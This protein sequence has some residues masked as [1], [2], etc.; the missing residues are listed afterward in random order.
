MKLTIRHIIFCSVTAVI[1]FSSCHS[2][3]GADVVPPQMENGIYLLEDDSSAATR[4][5]FA[6]DT[7]CGA[8]Y[9]DTLCRI[10]EN[11]FTRVSVYSYADGSLELSPEL[12]DCGTVRRDFVRYQN[13]GKSFAF[14][15]H[16]EVVA[17]GTFP[18]DTSTTYFQMKMKLLTT[19]DRGGQLAQLFNGEKK[20]PDTKRV[21]DS[22]GGWTEKEYYPDGKLFSEIFF[23]PEVSGHDRALLRTGV[24]RKCRTYYENGNLRYEKEQDTLTVDGIHGTWYEKHFYPQGKLMAVDLWDNNILLDREYFLNG[25]VKR[26]SR[27]YE[28]IESEPSLNRSYTE[29]GELVYEDSVMYLHVCGEGREFNHP[30][31]IHT[32]YFRNGKLTIE[33]DIFSDCGAE[34]NWDSAGTWTF[35]RDGIPVDVRK[36]P[37]WQKQYADYCEAETR[38]AAEMKNGK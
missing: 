25:N 11:N 21:V 3:R 37:S 27:D 36:F 24:A 19:K 32:K 26:D 31:V 5:L 28:T 34:C 15:F 33:G 2:R 16:N 9:A 14:V 20:T 6:G 18:S 8:F 7:G 23:G 29:A 12:T 1:V 17:T 30:Q 4:T 13:R 10:A 22:T 35:C 38:S